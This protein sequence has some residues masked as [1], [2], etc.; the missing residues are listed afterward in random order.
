MHYAA[1]FIC[2][3]QPVCFVAWLQNRL[4]HDQIEGW[5][6]TWN[7]KQFLCTQRTRGSFHRSDQFRVSRKTSGCR[8]QHH[9]WIYPHQ[10]SFLYGRSINGRSH[11]HP[12]RFKSVIYGGSKSNNFA[13]V[14]LRCLWETGREGS[15]ASGHGRPWHRPLDAAKYLSKHV[16]HITCKVVNLSFDFNLYV[17]ASVCAPAFSVWQEIKSMHTGCGMRMRMLRA[18]VLVEGNPRQARRW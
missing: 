13:N 5:H 1:V 17:L 7:I 14:K 2:W 12:S 15:S 3:H 18:E 9:D 11:S 6:H 4:S 8:Q 10:L 16:F